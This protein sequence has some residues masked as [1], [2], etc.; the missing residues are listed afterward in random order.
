MRADELKVVVM[1]NRKID[2]AKAERDVDTAWNN[3]KLL[4][5]MEKKHHQKR[6]SF[7][8]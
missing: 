2:E 5:K 1:L 4:H 3:L 8:L 6:G 7:R